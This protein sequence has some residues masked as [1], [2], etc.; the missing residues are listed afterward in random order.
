MRL[1]LLLKHSRFAN[2]IFVA[3]ADKEAAQAAIKAFIIDRTDM[4]LSR[5]IRVDSHEQL[6][7]FVEEFLKNDWEYGFIPNVVIRGEDGRVINEIKF[8]EHVEEL[9]E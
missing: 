5:E 8:N 2:Y 9:P 4:N 7:G 6:R 3:M 1:P